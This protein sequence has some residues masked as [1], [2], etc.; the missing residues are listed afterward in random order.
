MHRRNFCV[1][2]QL[3][4]SEFPMSGAL[5][6]ADIVPPGDPWRNMEELR[7]FRRHLYLIVPVNGRCSHGLS[8]ISHAP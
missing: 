2:V 4:I 5:E 6:L 3:A 8:V 1:T 7:R